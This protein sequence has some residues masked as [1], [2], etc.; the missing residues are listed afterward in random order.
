VGRDTNITIGLEIP[1]IAT[2]PDFMKPLT[3][4]PRCVWHENV[5]KLLYN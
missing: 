5:I 3:D 2:F 4:G 1:I